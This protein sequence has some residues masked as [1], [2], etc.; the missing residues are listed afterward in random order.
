MLTLTFQRFLSGNVQSTIAHRFL[1]EQK[2]VTAIS[3]M[4]DEFLQ[5]SPCFV[6]LSIFVIVLSIALLAQ[7]SKM[8]ID[9]GFEMVVF[10]R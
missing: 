6:F 5:D 10:H 4:L 9:D 7:N 3:D 8:M 2:L 1:V